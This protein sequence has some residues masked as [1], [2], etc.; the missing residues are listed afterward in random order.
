MEEID[1]AGINTF[2]GS[3]QADLSDITE[4]IDIAA[5]GLPFDGGAT[6]RPGARYG[7]EGIRDATSKIRRD[8]QMSSPNYNFATDRVA[9]YNELTI[10]DFGDVTVIPNDI[11]A[12]FDRV[13][14]AVGTFD[15][16]V[17]PILLGGDHS[18]T[19]PAFE[20]RALEVN[21]DIG[22]VQ[23]DAHTDTWKTDELYGDY[24]HGSPM[25]HIAESEFGDY[26]NHAVVGLRG[27]TDEHFLEIVN[28]E[29]LL[30][31]SMSDIR[32]IGIEECIRDAVKH[33]SRN[34]NEVYLTIDID[35]VD[36]AFAPGTGTPVPGGITSH[37]FL[38]AADIL[39]DFDCISV[40]DLME[41]AP[42]SDP[43]RTTIDLTASFLS[44]FLQSY[45]YETV[46]S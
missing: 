39:G 10:R 2:F 1:Y 16:D 4:S 34:V 38:T 45:F 15:T 21:E 46:T 31:R 9:S 42:R 33:A 40:V 30:A 14:E 41:V 13:R 35:V 27:H 19:Y 43:G 17:L 29:S 26:K 18:L 7:P 25:A 5:L 8:F 36:P 28:E 37:E 20:A 12:T 24:Y 23:I 6:N 44:R 3:D 22:L 32:E 11:S